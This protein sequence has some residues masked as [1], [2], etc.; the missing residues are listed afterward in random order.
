[1]DA[2]LGFSKLRAALLGRTPSRCLNVLAPVTL[3]RGGLWSHRLG[4]P[5]GLL[6]CHEG[7]LWLTQEGDASDHVLQAGEA[8]RMEG[9]GLVVVQALGAA[10]FSV[11][12][13][14][15]LTWEEAAR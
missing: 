12:C 15:P 7:S 4:T 13:E 6:H 3:G 8:L 2:L 5:G 10:R 14:A 11:S 9:P 1:M